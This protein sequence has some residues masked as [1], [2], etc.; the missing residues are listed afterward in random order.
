ME[1]TAMHNAIM[2]G[3]LQE[4]IEQMLAVVQRQAQLIGELQAREAE[5]ER[6]IEE[7]IKLV[8]R[9]IEEE[10]SLRS[11]IASV[12]S[13]IEGLKRIVK[14]SVASLNRITNEELRL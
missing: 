2:I 7:L 3:N 8:R 4:K 5:S 10:Q 14:E 13:E 12:Y 11:G 6:R 9:K 1:P